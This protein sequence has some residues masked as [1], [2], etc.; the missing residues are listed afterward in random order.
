[1]I[2]PDSAVYW[3]RRAVAGAGVFGVVLLVAWA[4]SG[5]GA[6]PNHDVPQALIAGST[7][8][9]F[10]PPSDSNTAQVSNVP[11]SL[12]PLPSALAAGAGGTDGSAPQALAPGSTLPGSTG[13]E[14][15][16][17]G[18]SAL[19]NGSPGL[20]SQAGAAPAL[21]QNAAPNLDVAP[22]QNTA[23]P[24]NTAP[25][26]ALPNSSA[27]APLPNGAN[28]DTVAPGNV[29][30]AV[31]NQAGKPDKPAKPVGP[32]GALATG[33]TI[34]P[35]APAATPTCS[36]DNI[37]LVAQ[38]SAPTFKIG[39]RP[40]FR[41]VIANLGSVPC[42]RNLDRGLRELV[43]TNASGARVW[44]GNDCGVAHKTEVQVLE[45]GKPLAFPLTWAG[46]GSAPGCTAKRTE[47]PPGAYQ[48]TA[49]L[50]PLTSGAAPF[51]LTK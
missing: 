20:P 39:Q 18:A 3:R 42:A 6:P 5:T 28:L 41:L 45:P 17:S 10:Q 29:A 26:T 21:P 33:P 40:V 35:P 8:L 43:V 1:M 49:K 15:A 14:P 12:L 37:G 23:L 11:S 9:T 48:L 44:D 13:Y 2:E 24:N 51:T 19:P 38:V 34:K 32:H 36:D 25:N 30:Q 50:G 47:L 31:P 46:R 22:S 16:L 4:L 7:Q 27:D